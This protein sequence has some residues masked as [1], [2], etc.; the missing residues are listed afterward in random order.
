MTGITIKLLL[1]ANDALMVLVPETS[2]FPYVANEDTPLPFIVY[3]NIKGLPDYDKN[4]LVGDEFTFDIYSL[5]NDYAKLQAVIVQVRAALELK[6]ATNTQRI[7]LTEYSETGD[8]NIWISKQSFST[9]Q[10]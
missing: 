2:V 6:T 5:H 9:Y 4:G 3:T 10:Y 8:G 7:L 1:V